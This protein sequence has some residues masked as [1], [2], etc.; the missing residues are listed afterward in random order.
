ML[1]VRLVKEQIYYTVKIREN[2]SA[3]A[4]DN[5]KNTTRRWHIAFTPKLWPQLVVVT[6]YYYYWAQL[7]AG[8]VGGT[9]NVVSYSC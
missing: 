9:S 8:S 5:N 2:K 4:I 1:L 3:M 6:Y 7:S